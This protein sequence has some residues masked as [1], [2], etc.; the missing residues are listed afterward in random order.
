MIRGRRRSV[1]PLGHRNHEL[2]HWLR[3]T[4]K[5]W[6]RKNR[7]ASHVCPPSH[8]VRHGN[9]KHKMR[10]PVPGTV[11]QSPLLRHHIGHRA[12]LEGWQLLVLKCLFDT[13]HDLSFGQ[14]SQCQVCPL[15]SDWQNRSCGLRI[16]AARTPILGVPKLGTVERAHPCAF[17]DADKAVLAF[18]RSFIVSVWPTHLVNEPSPC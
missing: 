7:G 6:I 2:G 13:V 9:V 4:I 15:Q 8:I 5:V 18:H 14:P 16:K 17:Y 1:R 3:S 11:V 10:N 12:R